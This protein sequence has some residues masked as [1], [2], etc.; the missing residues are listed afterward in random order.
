MRR[1]GRG[2]DDVGPG[3]LA[4]QRVEADRLAVKAPRQAERPVATAVGDEHRLGAA[5]GERAGG[6]LARLARARSTTT[7]RPLSLPS[8][9]RASATATAGRLSACSLI[10]VSV[11]TRLPVA[12]AALNR[13]LVSG[14]V[15]SLASARVVGA[16]DLPLHL[17]LADDHR[18]EAGGHAV[19]VPRSVAVA[20]RVD[21]AA[22]LR[23]ADPGLAGEHRQGRALGLDGVADDQVELGPVAGRDRDRLADLGGAAQ[24]AHELGRSAVG[25]RDAL[26]H[27]DRRGLVRDADRQQLA[28]SAAGSL[29]SRSC[30][31]SPAAAS[32]L[33]V[34]LEV[35]R[36][37][38]EVAL[39]AGEPDGH[40][41]HVDEQQ[42]D[43]HDVGAGDV[44]AG[45]VQRQR[46]SGLDEHAHDGAAL[47][48]SGR[49]AS[50]PSSRRRSR[51][52]CMRAFLAAISYFHSV[53][54]RSAMPISETRKVS[55]IGPGRLPPP[56][57]STRGMHEPLREPHGEEVE[58]H[59]RPRHDR[60]HARVARL[61]LGILDREAQRLIGGEEQEHDQE[62]D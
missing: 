22:E 60:E 42:R 49:T 50:S 18:V 2:D 26:A 47:R 59:E 16:L 46:R 51:R 25:Q 54:Y 52:I 56:S 38:A 12:S 7:A 41:R 19:Q 40:D 45:R 32:A 39:G 21:R 35:A 15:V 29:A 48:P 4:R 17:D 62:R 58:R 11:R 8:C 13:W 27:L 24:V 23:G 37:L 10:A 31:S 44:L 20:V 36:E 1:R 28:H 14:P 30:S 34:R 55:R 9:S 6:Q 57:V 5:V 53:A 3:E 61:A 43:E 33:L